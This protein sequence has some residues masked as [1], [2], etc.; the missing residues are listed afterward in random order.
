MNKAAFGDVLDIDDEDVIIDD[1]DSEIDN[2]FFET[3]YHGIK[4]LI[5]APHPDDEINVAGNMILNLSRARAEI[6][7]AYTT[8]GDFEI[9]AAIRAVEAAEALNILGV[10]RDHIFFLGYGDTFNGTGKPH[11]FFADMP[12][13]SPAGH[14]E[15]Y[16]AGDFIDYAYIKRKNHSKYTRQSYL[17][18]LK[19]LIL[20]IEADVIFCV[21]FDKHADHRMLSISFEQV[22][23]EILLRQGN[24]YKPEIYK[25]FAYSTAF[26]AERDFYSDNLKE[27]LQPVINKI[28]SYDF[29]LINRANYIWNDRARFPIAEDCRKTLL[30][31]NP[32]AKAIFQHKSQRNEWNALGIIN[33][34]EIYFERRTDNLIYMAK[35]EATSGDFQ[36]VS[37]F[38]I[39]NTAD[40]DATPPK[41]SNYLWIPA[42]NDTE[43]RL[44]LTWSCLQQIEQVKIYSGI[45]DDSGFDKLSV[46]FDDVYEIEID[47]SNSSAPIVIDFAEKI[48][49]TSAEF[50]IIEAHGES[51]GI[52]EIEIFANREPVKI[53]KPFIKITAADNFIYNYLVPNDVD[54]ICLSIYRFHISKPVEIIVSGGEIE[55]NGDNF[56]VNL[57]CDEVAVRAQ[58]TDEP[59]IFD[60]IKICRVSQF[61][62]W[63]L[64][65]NQLLERL[66]IHLKRKFR[67]EVNL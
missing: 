33:S 23:A 65:L 2:S 64:R 41:F 1:D 28:E 56:I 19:D 9:D 17:R 25:R 42:P 58:I 43:R 8:N 34:D 4:V 46:K 21:D 38:H 55:G 11:I 48:F 47:F 36:K 51:C 54:K 44:T 39:I 30:A 12:T 60:Q 52:S 15:T 14:V 67:F 5:L 57:N 16:P 59:S 26:T 22:I 10:K 40:I 18:D 27:T 35:I 66:K 61:Y 63:R 20:D 6:F 50:K 62:F 49:A 53:I 31:D 37:D 45:S 24:T 32:I 7:V 13:K 29:D 3:R